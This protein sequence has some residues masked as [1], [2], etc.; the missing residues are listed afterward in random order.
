MDKADA[1]TKRNGADLADAVVTD[2]VDAATVYSPKGRK[3]TMQN[4]P[5]YGLTFCRDG[6]CIVYTQD[7]QSYR[8]DCRHAVLLPQGGNYT[9]E[10]TSDGSFPV[11]NFYTLAPICERITV[12]EIKSPE[13]LVACYEEIRRLCD[14]E[15]NRARILS[16]LYRIFAELTEE[17]KEPSALSP[18]LSY[19]AT[20]L[21]DP[22]LSNEQLATECR[23]SEVYFRRL[24]R[25]QNGTSPKQYILSLRL[26]RA[27]T[28]LSEGKMKIRAVALDCGFESEA[29]FCRSFKERFAMTP[30]EYREKHRKR[31]I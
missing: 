2:V 27:Q 16:L 23:M 10:G 7:G 24:F 17:E 12:F 29:H 30:S 4:R 28:L 5:F 15:G 8:E 18:A 20:H 21:C 13:I 25:R 26:Q 3:V 1:L 6:G 14:A 31:G 11:I 19:L 22:A 9:L